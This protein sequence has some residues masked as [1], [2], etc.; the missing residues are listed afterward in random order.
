MKVGWLADAVEVPGGAELTQAEFRAAAPAGV[1]V[2]DCPPDGLEGLA[3]CDVACVHNSVTY[4]PETVDAL[5]GR[6]VLRYWHDLARAGGAGRP[7]ARPLGARARDERLHLAAAPRPLPAPAS[8]AR[9]TW[10][11][12][13]STSRAFGRSAPQ[14]E[15]RLLARLGDARRQGARPGVRVGRGERAGGLLGRSPPERRRPRRAI[16]V[17]GL[18]PPEYV[19]EI[20]ARYERF[21]FL[22]TTVEPFGRAVVE[23]WAA[24]CELI[25]NR[26]VGAL[27]WLEHPDGLS[28]AAADFWRLVGELAAETR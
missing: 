4:P 7:G 8:N 16:K 24:G 2:V 14:A 25:V 22:P 28:T 11:L 20:L 17:K 12:P 21:V 6:P 23:A 3:G 15:R 5:A 1:E 26:N 13:R 9:A 27:H 19:P 10:S 18:V